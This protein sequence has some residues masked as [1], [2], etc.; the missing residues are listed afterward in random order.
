[1]T[2]L[3]EHTEYTGVK[4]T[5]DEYERLDICI[6]EECL[7]KIGKGLKPS[8]LSFVCD[9][10]YTDELLKELQ[11][12]DKC[13]E[14]FAEARRAIRHDATGEKYKKTKKRK[15]QTAA[16]CS[17]LFQNIESAMK[18]AKVQSTK[19]FEGIQNAKDEGEINEGQYLIACNNT[20]KLY[21]EVCG[22]RAEYFKTLLVIYAN[23]A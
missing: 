21:D 17:W 4:M 10:I 8:I 7:S 19:W 20:K 6:C 1:M 5:P 14:D 9:N 12:N 23:L 3:P 11:V 13:L 18:I 22:D 2:T 15:N 16:A